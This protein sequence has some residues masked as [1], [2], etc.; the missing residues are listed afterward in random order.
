[1]PAWH[2]VMSGLPPHLFA[3]VTLNTTPGSALE[4]LLSY[5]LK[6]TIGLVQQSV[7]HQRSLYGTINKA[8]LVLV[9]ICSAYPRGN[10]LSS[11]KAWSTPTLVPVPW[12]RCVA[13]AWT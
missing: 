13:A 6:P 4:D 7:L 2:F 11:S 1:M 10:N 5:F 9:V 8:V 12:H 3:S